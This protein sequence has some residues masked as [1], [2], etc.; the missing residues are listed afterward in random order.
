[1]AK[2]QQH[3]KYIFAFSIRG[4]QSQIVTYT[5]NWTNRSIFSWNKSCLNTMQSTLPPPLS[6]SPTALC[7]SLLHYTKHNNIAGNITSH[8]CCPGRRGLRTTKDCTH[9]Q[10]KTKSLAFHFSLRARIA[11][12]FMTMWDWKSLFISWQQL[13]ERSSSLSNS[14]WSALVSI[15][16]PLCFLA[17][18][19]RKEMLELDLLHFHSYIN[20]N[21]TEV[22]EITLTSGG[23]LRRIT[24]CILSLSFDFFVL[25]HS[26]FK[27]PVSLK[28]I[29]SALG[30][31][32][33]VTLFGTMV[34]LL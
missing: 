1:M 32:N 6:T 4:A 27:C 7:H 12:L 11:E 24:E 25:F 20:T 31:G 5:L 14:F 13:P 2:W 8:W 34:F 3:P 17:R 33:E 18:Y 15:W 16:L 22:N 9:W 29:Y 23:Y 30:C 10:T 21:F 19:A 28:S 26:I